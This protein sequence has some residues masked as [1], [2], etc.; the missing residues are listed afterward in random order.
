MIRQSVRAFEQVVIMA[1]AGQ[2]IGQPFPALPGTPPDPSR[3]GS[4][5]QESYPAWSESTLNCM[6]CKRSGVR[7]PLAP[8]R[9]V[10]AGQTLHRRPVQDC[11]HD[12]VLTDL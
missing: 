8:F 6:A 10:S 9:A 5:R 7:L 3:H 1:V 12:L 4:R 2:P 11:W